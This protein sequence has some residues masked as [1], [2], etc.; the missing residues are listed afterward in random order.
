MKFSFLSIVITVIFGFLYAGGR[1]SY[2]E[3]T[4][5]PQERYSP[6]RRSSEGA[7]TTLSKNPQQ[8]QMD[9]LQQEYQ[10]LQKSLC[11]QQPLSMPGQSP[12]NSIQGNLS[13]KCNFRFLGFRFS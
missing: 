1:E 13:D 4:S 8:F 12:V 9:Q 11:V 5:W 6:V 10:N 7:A 2:K 3:I